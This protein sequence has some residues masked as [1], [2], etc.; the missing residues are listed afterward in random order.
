MQSLFNFVHR[1]MTPNFEDG[2][3][4]KIIVLYLGK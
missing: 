1:I 3:L 4:L 2:E